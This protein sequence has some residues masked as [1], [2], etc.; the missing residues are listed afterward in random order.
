MTPSYVDNQHDEVD[1]D[2]DKHPIEE[3]LDGFI[4]T[5]SVT[6]MMEIKEGISSRNPVT[7]HSNRPIKGRVVVENGE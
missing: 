1:I 2:F 5:A 3:E 6:D 4:D 7:E